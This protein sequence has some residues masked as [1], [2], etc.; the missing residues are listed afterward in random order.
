W[1]RR[2]RR[3]WPASIAAL[4]L[5]SVFAMT[6]ATGAQR[7]ALGGQ[8]LAAAANVANWA[9]ILRDTSYVEQFAAPSPVQHFW[10]LSVEEQFYVILPLALAAYFHRRRSLRRLQW[11]VVGALAATTAW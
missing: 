4:G 2:V 11:L 5:I 10:S 7:D 9:F 6:V 8:V 3:L 1:L